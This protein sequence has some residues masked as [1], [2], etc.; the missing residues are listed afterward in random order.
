MKNKPFQKVSKP[1]LNK[2]A[3][4]TVFII[5]VILLIASIVLFLFFKQGLIPGVPTSGE[6]NPRVFLSSCIEDNVKDTIKLI[7]EQGGYISN[8]LNKSFDDKQISYLCYNKNQYFPCVNQEPLLIQHLKEE[9]HEEISEEVETCFT[10]LT[11]SLESQNYIVDARYRGF[12]VD[13]LP[14][15]AIVDIKGMLT[16]TRSEETTTQEDFKLT[17]SS[18]IYDL[19]VITQEIVSQEAEYCN[20]EHLGYM[21]LHSDIDIFRRQLGDQTIIYGITDKKSQEGFWF[22]VRSCALPG[23]I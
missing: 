10:D 5:I 8:D 17:I 16:L 18:K 11:L 19:A 7:S 3:Q 21:L 15:K 12:E 2:R 13:L 1:E 14:R 22:A 9:I 23:S 20:F 4:V 6:T